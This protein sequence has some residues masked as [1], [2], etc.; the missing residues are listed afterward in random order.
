MSDAETKEPP[1]TLVPWGHYL[2]HLGDFCVVICDRP[3]EHGHFEVWHSSYSSGS[4]SRPHKADGRVIM[5]TSALDVRLDTLAGECLRADVRDVWA[6]S[7]RTK[8][9]IEKHNTGEKE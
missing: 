6:E 3:D 4:R 5:Q 7:R 9:A 1:K 2:N 8:A